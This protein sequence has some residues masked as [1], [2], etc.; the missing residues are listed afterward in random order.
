MVV[1]VAIEMTAVIEAGLMTAQI[2][3]IGGMCAETVGVALHSAVMTE[4]GIVNGETA[5][6]SA[7]DEHLLRVEDAHQIYV[8]FAM[9]Q[10]L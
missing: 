5:R 7:T 9:L 10:P 8:I 1:D 6:P 2:I 3:E 4:A